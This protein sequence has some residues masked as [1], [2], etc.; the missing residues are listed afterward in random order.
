MIGKAPLRSWE[1][2]L[3]SDDVDKNKE[4]RDRFKEEENEAIL[5]VITYTGLTPPWPIQ[6]GR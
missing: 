5:F 6:G 3:K 2:S 1:L 4:I